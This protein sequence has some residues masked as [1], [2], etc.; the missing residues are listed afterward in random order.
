M[1]GTLLLLSGLVT[2]VGAMAIRELTRLADAVPDLVSLRRTNLN[3]N[4]AWKFV[5]VVDGT[6]K[7]IGL[8]Q[9]Q[10]PI[11]EY[12]FFINFLKQQALWE[13]M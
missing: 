1:I 4:Y 11:E 7:E 12:L 3:M 10:R 6:V 13:I 8:H 5:I 9:S 2:L